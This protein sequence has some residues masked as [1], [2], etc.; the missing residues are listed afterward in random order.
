MRLLDKSGGSASP[1]F[2]R[3][4]RRS[5]S[6]SSPIMIRASEPPMKVRRFFKSIIGMTVALLIRIIPSSVIDI[7]ST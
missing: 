2:S 5:A 4:S 3:Q 6:S 7:L 1:R